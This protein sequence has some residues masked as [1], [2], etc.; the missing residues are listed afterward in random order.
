M[1][2]NVIKK[3]YGQG[4]NSIGYKFKNLIKLKSLYSKLSVLRK[5]GKEVK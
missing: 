3:K 5:G 4:A 1:I 2:L